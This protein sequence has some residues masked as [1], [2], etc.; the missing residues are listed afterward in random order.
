M[1][2]VGFRA[3]LFLLISGDAIEI[4]WRL[5]LDDSNPELLHGDRSKRN[6]AY[7][8]DGAHL[9]LGLDGEPLAIAIVADG[10]PLHVLAVKNIFFKNNMADLGRLIEIINELVAVI[11]NIVSSG[12]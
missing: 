4:N 8:T 2:K 10:E 3:D 6:N 9:L 7:E 5:G 11:Q 12:F 1:K